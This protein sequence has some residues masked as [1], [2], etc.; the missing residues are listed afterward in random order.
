MSPV[1][2]F[3][4]ATYRLALNCHGSSLLSFVLI[5]TILLCSCLNFLTHL[6]SCISTFSYK[7]LLC[8]YLA[9]YHVIISVSTSWYPYNSIW[10]Q[11]PLHLNTRGIFLYLCS[12]LLLSVTIPL[13]VATLFH[14]CLSPR[15]PFCIYSVLSQEK[16]IYL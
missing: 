6:C 4:K 16:F 13:L 2:T 15:T 11:Y 14:F 7:L 10:V 3:L 12:V 1:L 8:S 5:F 9:T